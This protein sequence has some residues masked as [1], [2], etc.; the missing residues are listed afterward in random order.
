MTSEAWETGL[1][2]A[3]EKGYQQNNKKGRGKFFRIKL[4]N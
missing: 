4:I 2:E 3:Q 1:D